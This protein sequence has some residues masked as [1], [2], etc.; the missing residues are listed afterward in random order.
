MPTSSVRALAGAAALLFLALL[1][2]RATAQVA[3]DSAKR[4]GTPV[5]DS[6]PLGYGDSTRQSGVDTS[7]TPPAADSARQGGR[8]SASAS[9]APA[10]PIPMDSVLSSACSS[11]R[12]GTVA[13]GL[14]LVVFRDGATSEERSAAVTAAGGISAGTASAGGEYVRAAGSASARDLA[15]Q[16]ALDPAVASVSERSCPVMGRH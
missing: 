12:A 4:P 8:D 7:R 16:L 1:P 15:D 5:A 2:I 13:P 6:Q 10:A 14:V 9:A 11:S 3:T